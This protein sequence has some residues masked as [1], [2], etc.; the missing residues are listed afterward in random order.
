MKK[1]DISTMTREEV[2]NNIRDELHCKI[3]NLLATD[4]RF[5]NVVME[6]HFFEE[7][8][9]NAKRVSIYDYLS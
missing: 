9:K 7:E 2:L 5:L 6:I 8:P 3:E 1:V 4:E